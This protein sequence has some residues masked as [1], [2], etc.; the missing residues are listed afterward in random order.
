MNR[1]PFLAVLASSAASLLLAGHT[2]YR[3]WKLYRQAHLLIFTSRDDPGSD[4]LGERIAARLRM[5][6]PDSNARVRARA[7][8]WTASP[9]S[10]P[11][12]QADVAVLSHANAA[13]LFARQEPFTDYAAVAL[14]VLVQT[15][16]YQ[17]V[18][19]EDFK[20]EHAYL[21]AEALVGDP[22]IPAL[23]VPMSEHAGADEVPTHPG[24]L[25]FAARRAFGKAVR[26]ASSGGYA[27][28][29]VRRAA[30]WRCVCSVA[31]AHDLITAEAAERYLAQAGENRRSSDRR[32]PLRS[33]PRPT[34]RWGRCWT[35]SATCSTATSRP[36]ARCRACRPSTW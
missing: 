2:P 17:L 31:S 29:A 9:A 7:D 28:R 13:A 33:A 16:R 1:R 19:R 14:R 22:G 20:L 27:V 4:E 8:T 24:R 26:M 18:C 15:A 6:L 36:T 35:R 3:Q 34:M 5:V 10:S 12:S 25:A 11:P 32:R 21:V 23:T 30:G